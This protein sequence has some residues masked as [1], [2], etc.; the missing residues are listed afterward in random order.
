M[1]SLN[2]REVENARTRQIISEHSH[3]RMRAIASFPIR[4]RHACD[5]LLSIIEN[6]RISGIPEELD[7]I[8]SE[9]ERM[10]CREFEKSFGH[11]MIADVQEEKGE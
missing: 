2:V 5:L 7:G 8:T 9:L 3:A 1:S 4:I 10:I 11:S 6:N